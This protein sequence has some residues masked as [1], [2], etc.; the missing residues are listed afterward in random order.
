[1]LNWPIMVYT[2]GPSKGG[3][4]WI[5][6]TAANTKHIINVCLTVLSYSRAQAILLT[7]YLS[8]Y[9]STFPILKLNNIQAPGHLNIGV[10]Q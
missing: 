7:T 5:Q 2:D 4:M 10:I 8:K 1:M 6:L 9:K 3:D